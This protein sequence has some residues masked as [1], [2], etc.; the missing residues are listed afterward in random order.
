[1]GGLV[2]A[3]DAESCHG[4]GAEGYCRCSEHGTLP[5]RICLAG[6]QHDSGIGVVSGKGDSGDCEYIGAFHFPCEFAGVQ[7]TGECKA[8]GCLVHAA[9]MWRATDG[10]EGTYQLSE[11]REGDR[12]LCNRE[13]CADNSLESSHNAL[14]ML[15]VE[16]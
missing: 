3:D 7:K 1:M 2:E 12:Q 16:G 14:Q 6:W 13:G 10:L 11:E 8:E 9:V 5:E 4:T 15:G